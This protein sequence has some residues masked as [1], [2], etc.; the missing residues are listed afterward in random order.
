MPPSTI[1]EIENA[2]KLSS[3]F[4]AVMF[5][6]DL[7]VAVRDFPCALDISELHEQYLS[8]RLNLGL[9]LLRPKLKKI[10]SHSD[11]YVPIKN[12]DFSDGNS[13]IT[14]NSTSISKSPVSAN[15]SVNDATSSTAGQL[16]NSKKTPSS[17]PPVVGVMPTPVPPKDTQKP[18]AGPRPVRRIQ[19]VA[20]TDGKI[21]NDDIKRKQSIIRPNSAT[22]STSINSSASNSAKIASRGSSKTQTKSANTNMLK[23]AKVEGS[24]KVMKDMSA[25]VNPKIVAES[26]V[27]SNHMECPDGSQYKE[28]NAPSLSA[29]LPPVHGSNNTSGAVN[30]PSNNFISESPI[31]SSNGLM[32]NRLHTIDKLQVNG[33]FGAT[34][35][36]VDMKINNIEL[37]QGS[38]SLLQVKGSCDGKGDNN[39]DED[40][41]R[42]PNQAEVSD[43]YEEDFEEYE[44]D[45]DVE[46]GD[47][48]H[49]GSVVD[50]IPSYNVLPPS[51][52][53]PS[54]SGGR[55]GS[56][57]VSM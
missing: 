37:V 16:L 26:L 13:D 44:D 18:V 43:C 19:N 30:K 55:A 40:N 53:K 5:I 38:V 6:S 11:A 56:N 50:A 12:N 32:R 35:T 52:P 14:G 54:Y 29:F 57:I 33:E 34:N 9:P 23:T 8:N 49:K 31:D 48:G 24:S 7:I 20:A 36:P 27:S 47:V 28:L 1:T 46:E 42:M 45:F 2:L 17:A 15:L 39:N 51:N 21:L 41:N 22:S 25:K 4:E 3:I 10:K